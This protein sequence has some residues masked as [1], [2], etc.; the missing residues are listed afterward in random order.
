MGNGHVVFVGQVESMP[1]SGLIGDWIVG[2]KTV[3][4]NADTKIRQNDGP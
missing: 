2:G 1:S 4:V 3:H